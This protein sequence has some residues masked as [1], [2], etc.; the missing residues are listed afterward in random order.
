MPSCVKYMLYYTHTVF[1]WLQN[2]VLFK[3]MTSLE[4][5]LYIHHYTI[6]ALYVM[7]CTKST[8]LKQKGETNILGQRQI[9]V[10][11]T[12]FMTFVPGR[13]NT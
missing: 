3:P 11:G 13:Y 12:C 2:T 5:T 8:Q 1:T 6:N 9:V 7:V 10:C 4:P